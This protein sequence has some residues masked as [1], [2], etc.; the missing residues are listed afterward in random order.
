MSSSSSDDA[1]V[2]VELVETVQPSPGP[3]RRS[4]NR[5]RPVFK[6]QK[7]IIELT[8]EDTRNKWER[9]FPKP[10]SSI[11]LEFK[12]I[13]Y[14]VDISTGGFPLPLLEKTERKPILK[15]CSGHAAPGE[16]LVIIGPS[17]A[18]KTTLLNLLANRIRKGTGHLSGEIFVNGEPRNHYIKRHSSFVLQDDL[19]FSELT[20][21]ETLQ[22]TASAVVSG[23]AQEKDQRAK[24]F[25]DLFGLSKCKNT[26]VGN[27]I[28]RGLSGGEKKRLNIAN[29]MIGGPTLI[30]LDEPTSGLDATTSLD[31]LSMLSMLA[32]GGRTIVATLHQPSS[33]MFE[34]MDKVMLMA[35]G[36]VAYHGSASTALNYFYG[37]GFNCPDL[38]NPADFMLLLV[39]FDKLSTKSVSAKKLLIE[40]H[41][42]P[43]LP[44]VCPPPLSQNTTK[45]FGLS[46][47][48]QMLLLGRRAGKQHLA[49]AI[50]NTF[51]FMFVAAFGAVVWWNLGTSKD[52]LSDKAGLI[53]FNLINW[54]IFP[55]FQ[56]IQTII[57]E[58]AVLEKELHSDT[59]S[60]GAY[61]F[62]KTLTEFCIDLVTPLMFSSLLYWCAGLN[63]SMDAFF[64]FVTIIVVTV[65]LSQSVGIL[66]V[67]FV[68]SVESAPLVT[69][70]Y[71]FVN[72][73]TAGI[74]A[75]VDKIPVWFRW[76]Q[77][78]T[79][80]K[81]ISD[82]FIINEFDN[83]VVYKGSAASD[84]EP[85]TGEEF[86]DSTKPIIDTV[87]GNILVVVG[88]AVVFRT[89]GYC[90]M[91]YMIRRKVN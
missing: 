1:D 31:I 43:P 13:S 7:T 52:D 73:L 49:F 68:N 63:D 86:V 56:T 36:Q 2:A 48:L 75:N 27:P 45:R 74:Y 35:D 61:V 21:L 28:K 66:I 32:R 25:I 9:V 33:Q 41:K 88:M 76:V 19:F 64:L 82:A 37:L 62:A 23:T 71:M 10:P 18:G 60:I 90:V 54:F 20:A 72:M 4:S 65:V 67:S 14:D 85:L 30:F 70:V 40:S 8:D 38:F 51:M 12:N 87:W 42:P 84:D 44:S 16:L 80:M 5:E 57:P 53:F 24:D 83:D 39:Q 22:F 6:R 17:G 3:A 11:L 91:Y 58:R 89:V 78:A 15:D 59:Y 69:L 46:W 47:P 34:K 77:Y 50:F 79:S 29:E 26:K 81:Y 55:M